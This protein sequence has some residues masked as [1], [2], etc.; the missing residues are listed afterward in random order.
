MKWNRVGMAAMG[1]VV[2]M[3]VTFAAPAVRADDG[4]VATITTDKADYHPEETVIINGTWF[5]A[6]T[7]VTVAVTRPDGND[8]PWDVL[9]DN[10]GS[11]STTYQLDGI[12]GTYYADATDGT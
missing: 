3:L 6:D 8:S 10:A 12:Q 7:I 4:G 9:S 5:L 11:F 2:V 1:V